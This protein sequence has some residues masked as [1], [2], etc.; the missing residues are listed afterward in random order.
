VKFSIVQHEIEKFQE[1]LKPRSLEY[2]VYETVRHFPAKYTIQQV[3]D[4]YEVPKSAIART[5]NKLCKNGYWVFP[6]NTVGK[7][8]KDTHTRGVEPGKLVYALA[9]AM[10]FQEMFSRRIDRYVMPHLKYVIKAA[11]HGFQKFPEVR[12][13]VMNTLT[14]M[15][16]EVSSEVNDVKKLT[17]SYGK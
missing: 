16:R 11:S 12:T 4:M 8:A 7:K 3:A 14:M 5:I 6:T 17:T 9:N 13:A 10:Y 15:N 2:V 1:P